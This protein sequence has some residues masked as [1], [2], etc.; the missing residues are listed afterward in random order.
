MQVEVLYEELYFKTA[1]KYFGTRKTPLSA[2]PKIY[3][4]LDHL[5]I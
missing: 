3:Q 1:E 2:S 4:K 5:V